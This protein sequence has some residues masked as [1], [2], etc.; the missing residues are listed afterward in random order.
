MKKLLLVTCLLF[1]TNCV[2]AFDFMKNEIVIQKGLALVF[3]SRNEESQEYNYKMDLKY[4]QLSGEALNEA[5]QHFNTKMKDFTDSETTEFESKINDNLEAVKKLPPN[6]QKNTFTLNFNASVFNVT[7]TVLMGIRFNKEY[8]YAGDAHPSHDIEVY[9]Y[10]LTTGKEI[11]LDDIF[12][13]GSNYLKFISEYC[14]KELTKRMKV[15]KVALIPA[16]LDPKIE[17]YDMWNVEPDGLLFIFDE[18]QVVPYVAGQPEVFISYKTLKAL[19]TPSAPVAPCLKD[20][21]TC[22]AVTS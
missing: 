20:P 12:S 8:N 18:G 11:T 15:Q 5:S 4:P 1:Y 3:E 13:P 14:R 21:K 2:S 16:G 10:D 6:L 22:I 7:D 17:N 9:N 19:I